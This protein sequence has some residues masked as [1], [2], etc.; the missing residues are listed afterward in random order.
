MATARA[1]RR[2]LPAM[3]PT[4]AVVS[5]AGTVAAGLVAAFAFRSTS[6]LLHVAAPALLFGVAVWMFFSERYERTLA[7]LAL[8]LGLFDGFLKLKTGSTVATLGRDVLLY[9]I[10]SGA[11]VRLSLSRHR[12]RVP[13]LTPGVLVWVIICAAEVLNPVVPSFSHALAG[14]RQ[15]I[16]FVPLFFLG[17]AVM[18]T[19]RRLMGLFILLLIIAAANGVVGLIQSNLSP[20]ALAAW[21]PGYA[22]EVYGLGL[23][24][25]GARTF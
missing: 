9:S 5:V 1:G 17:Y 21:G 25:G 11:M 6:S 15:H 23:L 18:R 8:Y 13:K 2:T 10:A 24:T 16:E 4:A 12:L 3:V 19:E 14:V 7:V 20:A 22:K